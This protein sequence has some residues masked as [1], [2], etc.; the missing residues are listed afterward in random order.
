MF[1]P[2]LGVEWK[3]GDGVVYRAHQEALFRGSSAGIRSRIL[4]FFFLLLS[5]QVCLAI[6][7]RVK[8]SPQSWPPFLGGFGFEFGFGVIPGRL[9]NGFDTRPYSLLF[10]LACLDGGG[11]G[12]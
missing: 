4:F 7:D 6:D 11:G 3:V 9:L 2:R 5:G 12:R 1:K 8:L 10:L